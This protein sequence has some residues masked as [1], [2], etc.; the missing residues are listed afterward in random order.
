MN[1]AACQLFALGGLTSALWSCAAS[2]AD[3][4]IQVVEEFRAARK[5]GR[6]AEARRYLTDDP[7]IWY[8]GKAGAGSPWKLGGGRWQAWD[9]HFRS[10]SERVTDWRHEDAR[11]W[12]DI[13]ETNEYFKLT[14]R[15]GS[16]WRATYYFDESGQITGFM[17][18]GVPGVE[19]ERGRR[20]EF[21]PGPGS[22]GPEKR[23]T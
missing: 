7:R 3:V 20:D 21:E 13:F 12:A 5:A 1:R 10:T 19:S 16:T 18:S 8:D 22:T 17:V 23:S 11:V 6:Y 14:E 4:H 2:H 15:G 9:D